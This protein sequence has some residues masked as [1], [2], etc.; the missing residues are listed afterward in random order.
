M[1][2]RVVLNFPDGF[3]C[4]CTSHCCLPG[5][6]SLL[7]LLLS[8][9][10]FVSLPS[11]A[12]KLMHKYGAHSGT[13]ITGFGLMGDSNKLAR[14]TEDKVEL[15]FHTLPIIKDMAKLDKPFAF[16]KLLKGFAPETSGA[17]LIMIPA[18]NADVS[19]ADRSGIDMIMSALVE[20]V[21]DVSRWHTGVSVDVSSLCD[22]RECVCG[23]VSV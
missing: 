9:L 7:L 5:Y 10:D 19:T 14:E 12:A 22:R 21:I 13:D 20:H 23:A 2:D 6:F 11:L 1:A 3:R 18:E 8:I 16:F 15:V 4:C 17:L